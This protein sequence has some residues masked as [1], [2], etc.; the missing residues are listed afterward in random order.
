M[1]SSIVKELFAG[2]RLIDLGEVRVTRASLNAV[3]GKPR[4]LIYLP[5]SRN[6]VWKALNEAGVKIRLFAELPQDLAT[7]LKATD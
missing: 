3:R 2:S 5:V 6:Y 4:Y 1:S 7:K